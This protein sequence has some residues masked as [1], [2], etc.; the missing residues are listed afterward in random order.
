M[1]WSEA[2]QEKCTRSDGR[3]VAS[4]CTSDSGTGASRSASLGGANDESN[5]QPVLLKCHRAKTYGG[6]LTRGDVREIAKAKRI[7]RRHQ[8]VRSSRPVRHHDLVRSVDGTV[9]VRDGS[10]ARMR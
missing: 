10:E 8:G 4:S 6:R 1:P 9:S 2:T 5:L 7:A 3:G